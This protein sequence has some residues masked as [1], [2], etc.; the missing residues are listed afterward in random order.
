VHTVALA[1][2][3]LYLQALRSPGKTNRAALASSL[4]DFKY[5]DR[6]AVEMD[7]NGR[8][9]AGADPEATSPNDHAGLQSKTSSGGKRI[10]VGMGRAKM[11]ATDGTTP[12]VN[13]RL[14]Y[15]TILGKRF[16][17]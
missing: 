10:G 15:T 9:S 7:F 8:L 3:T 2:S 1:H 11:C 5:Q 12:L 16:Q 6:H 17:I 13:R 14:K 4:A